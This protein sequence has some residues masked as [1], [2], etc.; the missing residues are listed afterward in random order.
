MCKRKSGHNI[1][2]TRAEGSHRTG[3]KK[4]P[5]ERYQTPKAFSHVSFFFPG[6]FFLLVFL[7]REDPNLCRCVLLYVSGR[8]TDTGNRVPLCEGEVDFI[9]QVP[10]LIC[11]QLLIRQTSLSLVG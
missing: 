4:T 2:G 5:Q 3:V 1:G 9:C 10:N 6:F 8:Y 7:V 11:Y